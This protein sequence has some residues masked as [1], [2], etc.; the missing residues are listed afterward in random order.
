MQG[1]LAGQEDACLQTA[2]TQTWFDRVHNDTPRP[3]SCIA[4]VCEL[5][6]QRWLHTHA[7][8]DVLVKECASSMVVGYL[9]CLSLTVLI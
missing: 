6:F 9:C 2:E 3:I 5:F 4:S 7:A 1:L 8:S